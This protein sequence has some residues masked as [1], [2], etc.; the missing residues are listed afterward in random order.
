MLKHSLKGT[1]YS[2]C[3]LE[4][5]IGKW[6][7]TISFPSK[8]E[9]KNVSNEP[10]SLYE[11]SRCILLY[12]EQISLCPTLCVCVDHRI[13]HEQKVTPTHTHIPT[14]ELWSSSLEDTNFDTITLVLFLIQT[15]KNTF[16]CILHSSIA[17]VLW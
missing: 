13:S 6:V 5:T 1:V 17:L 9:Q 15:L 16:M 11:L 14:L 2:D 4:K 3:M 8:K 12:L 7:R 10:T